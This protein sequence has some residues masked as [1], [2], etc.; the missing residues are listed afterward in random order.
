IDESILQ[1]A[2]KK[3]VDWRAL[4]RREERAFLEDMR[5]LGWRKPD[6]IPHATREIR[7]MIELAERLRRRGHAYDTPGG[8]YYDVSKFRRFGQ[9]SRYSRPRMRRILATQ[10]D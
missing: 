7:P 8:L 4:G 1:R 6:A 2:A 5:R 9:L 10:D 3:R